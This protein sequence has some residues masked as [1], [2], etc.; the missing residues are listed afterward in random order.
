MIKVEGK[1][2]ITASIIAHSKS[3][4]NGKE[5]ITY[6]LEYPRF[7]HAEFMTHRLF[8]RNSASSRAIPVSRMIELIREKPATFVHWGKNQAG[9]QAKEECNTPVF[10]YPGYYALMESTDESVDQQAAIALCEKLGMN[11][12]ESAWAAMAAIVCQ[13]AKAYS[14]AGYH[15]QI[16]NRLLEP[17]QMMKVV[18]TATEWD[19]FFHL[20][21]HVDAQPEIHELA[22][23]MLEA[24]KQSTPEVLQPGEW[25]TPYVDHARR[26]S[27]GKLLYCKLDENNLVT[28]WL[29]EEDALKVSCSCCAQVSYR[30]L[31]DSLEKAI[32]IYDRLVTSEPVH[33]SALE[34]CATPMAFFTDSGCCGWEDGVTSSDRE[35]RLWSGNFKSWVQYRQLIPN[36]VCNNYNEG[37]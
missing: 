20:R 7:I 24:K 19:N 18:C 1:A 9:M 30:K 32:A 6:E 34:H 17:F 21:N 37:N 36:H 16:V 3:A 22:R 5:I 33:A 15:K 29:S 10:N 25:H 23:V 31:D 11:T 12:R 13:Q 2:G 4:V 8:S 26:Q 27:D 35:N 28:E 14:D